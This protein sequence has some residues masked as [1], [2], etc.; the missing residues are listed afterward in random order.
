[1]E[2]QRLDVRPIDRA[3]VDKAG[4]VVGELDENGVERLD[5]HVDREGAGDGRETQRQAGQGIAPDRK[6][7]DAGERDQ[8]QIARIRRDARQDA[9]K[10][11]DI[12]QRPGRRDDHELPDQRRDEAGFLGDAGADHGDDHQP[13]GGEAHEVWDQ[14]RIHEANAVRG[15][16]ASDRRGRGLDLMR[17]GIDALEPDR[18]S[19]QAEDGRQS[20]D[21]SDQD[22]EDD[23]G[24]GN[25]VPHSFDTVEEPLHHGLRR[26]DCCR[27]HPA[28]PSADGIR[29]RNSVRPFRAC[30]VDTKLSLG[31][32]RTGEVGVVID[33]L[34]AEGDA[35]LDPI[36]KSI[37]R[38][39]S[40]CLD[41]EPP[42]SPTRFWMAN[43]R[44]IS[45][46][47]TVRSTI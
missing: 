16:Q 46:T 42:L 39:A 45:M 19:E 14:R 38:I 13:D 4:G 30:I 3:R 12:G 18:R 21:D 7:G 11:Q 47:P 29:C 28:S 2:N 9:H 6:V 33:Q 20:D 1:M 26:D 25:H 36:P 15:H 43:S 34:V 27:A 24:M 32:K 35:A 8:N 44:T 10:G 5:Q 41:R 31:N 22:E 23:H 17:L 40:F 37:R